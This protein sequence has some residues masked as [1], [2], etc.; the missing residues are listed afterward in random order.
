M[1][2]FS[3]T[4]MMLTLA[5]L[6]GLFVMFM[7]MSND[8]E[9]SWREKFYAERNVRRAIAYRYVD[10]KGGM[11]AES[12]HD[13]GPD[14]ETASMTPES[15]G[16]PPYEGSALSTEPLPGTKVVQ[17]QLKEVRDAGAAQQTGFDASRNDV[18]ETNTRLATEIGAFQ[19][20]RRE[21]DQRLAAARE[22]A[23]KFAQQM[24]SFRHILASDQQR[25]YNLDF[26]I[27]RAMVER[28]ALKAELAQVLND[29][30]RA[31]SQSMTLE[32]VY[33]EL[34]KSYDRTIKML[35]W[36]EQAAPNLRQMADTTGRG[37]LRGKVVAVGD[38]PR[39]GVVSISIGE[40]EGVKVGQ[41]FTI[42]RNDSF[43]AKMV[44]E[45][46]QKNGATG[47][48]MEEFRGTVI[49]EGDGVKTSEAFGGAALRK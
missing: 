45:N 33:W 23:R 46:V 18:S 11:V 9:P 42:F 49:A 40:H 27:H 7:F 41:H 2:V 39:T 43:V 35:A 19:R 13:K 47:R 38:D 28:D 26:E 29:I 22:S 15:L 48:V 21:H 14:S 31:D 6:V 30:T 16:N 1:G 8:T 32:D 36:Y 34:A 37:W 17:S 12:G 3:R 44:V 25:L 20:A 5:W 10:I 24:D 4:M